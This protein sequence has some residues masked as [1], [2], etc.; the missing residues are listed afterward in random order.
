MDS[1]REQWVMPA[2][3][4]N[5]TVRVSHGQSMSLSEYVT[6]RVCHCQ[7]MS[8]AEYVT[9]RVCHGQRVLVRVEC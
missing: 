8:R 7:S 4:S 5:F 9:V 2:H 6:V 1:E 3:L